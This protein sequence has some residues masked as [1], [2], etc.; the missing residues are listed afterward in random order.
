MRTT[1]L[2]GFKNLIE[3]GYLKNVISFNKTYFT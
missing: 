1:F 3:K 2:Q